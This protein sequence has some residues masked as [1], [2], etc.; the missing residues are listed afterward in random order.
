MSTVAELLTLVDSFY[1]NSATDATTVSYFNMAQNEISPYFGLIAE[2]TTL[3]TVAD[4]D[5][6]TLPTGIADISQIDTFDI[7]NEATDTD[8]IVTSANMKVGTYTIAAQPTS[9]KRLSV[10]H[11]AVGNTD[12]LGTITIAGTVDGTATTEVITPVANSTVYG[13]KF[14]DADG[15]TSITGAAWVTNGTADKIT[16]GVSLDRYDFT[17]YYLGYADDASYSGN[18]FYQIYTSAGV[19]SLVVYPVP[20]ETGRNIRIRYRKALTTLSASSTSVSPD[21]DS[22]F[23]DMLALYAAYMICSTGASADQSQSDR[24]MEQYDNRLTELWKYSMEKDKKSV[25]KRRD[26]GQWH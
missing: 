22:R 8:A 2:D 17:R 14:F 5:N 4:N 11:T 3:Y 19:K 6:F 9:A 12:T 24:F 13:N 10:T 18:I 25:M 20:T 16:V 23:H 26:N 7:Y 15:I 1:A 21:F